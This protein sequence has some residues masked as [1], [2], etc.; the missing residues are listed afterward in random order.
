MEFLNRQDEM[1]R[2]EMV[3]QQNEAALVVVWGRRRVG[4]SRLLAEWATRH[5]GLYWVGDE[6]GPA[7]QRRYLAAALEAVLPGFAAVD[8]PDWYSLLDRLSRD[9][10]AARWRGPLVL[11]ELPYLVAKSPELPSVLQKWIDR[12]RR[13]GGLVL[14]VAGSSQRMMHSAVLDATAPLYGRAD[15]ILKLEPL[16]FGFVPEAI[17]PANAAEAFA[18]FACWGG[19]PRYWELAAGYATDIVAAVD[20]LL[21]SP[22]GPLHDEVDRLLRQEMPSAI[23]LRPILDAIGMGSHR[24]S[25]IAG[26]LQQ[27]ATTLTRPLAQLQQLGYVRREVPWGDDEKRSKRSLYR[28]ADPF[29]RLWFRT[30]AA[31]RGALQTAT[32]A[33]RRQMFTAV[34][35]QLRGEAWEELCR[36][37]IPQLA[38]PETS[39]SPA[40]RSWAAGAAEWDAVSQS[41]S[42]DVLVL[43]ECKATAR[44]VGGRELRQMIHDLEAKPPPPTRKPPQKTQRWLCAPTFHSRRPRLPDHIR[45]IDAR[46]VLAALS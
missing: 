14:A 33:H 34:W 45:L 19:M 13:Q 46:D 20:D 12:E 1:R 2:L 23:S 35:P 7:I 44:P 10:R 27:P 31:H 3:A 11:D 6:S 4:K 9:A 32:A 36:A 16:T 28:L 24:S 17:G 29:L 39:L 21:L 18:F 30:V 22:L 40:M 42:G 5:V 38:L 25:E 15:Q 43:A 41:P 8:Y 37:A 26:R